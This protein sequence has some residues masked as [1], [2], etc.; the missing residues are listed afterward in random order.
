MNILDWKQKE[1]RMLD[2]IRPGEW[3]NIAAPVRDAI[4]ILIDRVT[5][6]MDQM[7]MMVNNV[8]QL[9]QRFTKKER[10]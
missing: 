3:I 1:M 7:T 5:S 2:G 4:A 9:D 6:I 8:K 10:R